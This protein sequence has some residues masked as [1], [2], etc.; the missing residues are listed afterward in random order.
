M[1]IAGDFVNGSPVGYIMLVMANFGTVLYSE[2]SGK[3]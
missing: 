2:Y 1:A 3:L